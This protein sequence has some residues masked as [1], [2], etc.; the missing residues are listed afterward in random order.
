MEKVIGKIDRRKNVL[1]NFVRDAV[2]IVLEA[3]GGSRSKSHNFQ[4]NF[5]IVKINAIA[6]FADEINVEIVDC[7]PCHHDTTTGYESSQF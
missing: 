2:M 3:A 1:K 4:D 7:H 5:L 6:F